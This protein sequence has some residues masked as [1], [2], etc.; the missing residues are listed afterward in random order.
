VTVSVTGVFGT[1]E[2]GTVTVF[3]DPNA[4]VQVVGFQLTGAIGDVLIWEQQSDEDQTPNWGM[5]GKDR[6]DS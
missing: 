1:A 5:I 6:L 4:L 3:I 2:L